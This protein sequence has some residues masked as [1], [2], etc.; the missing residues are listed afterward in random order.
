MLKNFWITLG[1]ILGA[2]GTAVLGF[3]VYLGFYTVIS[4]IWLLVSDY[5]IGT[6]IAHL[7]YALLSASIILVLKLFIFKEGE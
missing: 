6:S 7:N 4:F 5:L 1:A 2:V 3:A